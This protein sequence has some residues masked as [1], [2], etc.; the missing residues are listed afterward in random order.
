[1]RMKLNQENPRF[2]LGLL[3]LYRSAS[4]MNGNLEQ[5]DRLLSLDAFH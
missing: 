1:M 2:F 4:I 5:G 3:E